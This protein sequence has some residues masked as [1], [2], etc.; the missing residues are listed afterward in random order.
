MLPFN[1]T[2]LSK[3]MVMQ[4]RKIS[5]FEVNSIKY[6]TYMR[7]NG[8]VYFISCIA[9]NQNHHFEPKVSIPCDD[10]KKKYLSI[11]LILNSSTPPVRPRIDNKNGNIYFIQTRNQ[12]VRYLSRYH[13]LC[14]IFFL[15][16]VG[17]LVSRE[18]V[19]A[20]VRVYVRVL[21]AF[22]SI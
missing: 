17:M 12:S 4:M 18:L 21:C 7:K 14:K 6:L 15:F 22:V 8:R 2:N 3:S 19:Y 5:I 11:V 10:I 13:M 1:K 16:T 20:C 9:S